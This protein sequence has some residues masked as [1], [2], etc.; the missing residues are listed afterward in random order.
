MT[1]IIETKRDRY[2]NVCV[3]LHNVV[4]DVTHAVKNGETTLN[5]YGTDYKIV[6]LEEKESHGVPKTRR[7]KKA[8]K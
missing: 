3:K 4:Y 1:K 2:G 7:S 8:G 6:V 5:I